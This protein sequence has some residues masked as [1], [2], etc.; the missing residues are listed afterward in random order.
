MSALV[1]FKLARDLRGRAAR[2]GRRQAAVARPPAMDP[3]RTLSNAA[4]YIFVPALLFRTTARIEF[5]ALPW[6]TLLAYF[7]PVLLLLLVVYALGAAAQPRRRSPAA[8]PQ[9]ARDHRDL[10]Q[11]GP[12]RHPDG[13]GA[14]R[15]G[16]ARD[17]RHARQPASLTILTVLTAIVELDLARERHARQRRRA[18]L[19]A[20]PAHHGAQH[21][22]PPGRPAGAGRLRLE[23]A[24]ASACRPS[25]TR[26][27]RRSARPS[28]RSAWC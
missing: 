2:L 20:D 1:F 23:P 13:G 19:W 8:V 24:P 6:S 17:P 15:R 5:G 10:R 26:C 7:V 12:G 18:N 3:A 4:F 16:R 11:R 9:R 28:C 14:V 22:D 27:C 21:G 25:P